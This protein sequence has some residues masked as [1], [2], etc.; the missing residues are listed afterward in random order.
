MTIIRIQNDCNKENIQIISS[1]RHL[2]KGKY[3]DV[4]TS[5]TELIQYAHVAMT[6]YLLQ[7]TTHKPLP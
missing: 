1:F 5:I 2:G 3:L 6:F 7:T 4:S